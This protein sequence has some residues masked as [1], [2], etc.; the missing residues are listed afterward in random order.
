M[1][2]VRDGFFLRD[3][4][5]RDGKEF[6]STVKVG[7]YCFSI[8]LNFFNP[9]LNKQAGKKVSLGVISVVCLSLPA[10]LRYSLEN[11]FLAGVIPGPNEPPLTAVSHYL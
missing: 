7:R 9:F 1:K 6:Q 5:A 2:D 3:F 4:S 10:D 8:S 11:M